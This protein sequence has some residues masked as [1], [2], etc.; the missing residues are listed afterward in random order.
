M[1]IAYST[2]GEA[3]L[4]AESTKRS[5]ALRNRTS[6]PER[7][8]IDTMYDRQVTGNL[9]REL[10]TLTLWAQTY[11]RDVTAHGLLAGFATNGTGRYELCLE[12]AS[13]AKALDP[14]VVYTYNSQIMCNL[15]LERLDQAERA[16]QQ[17]A[18]TFHSPLLGLFGYHLAFL[19]G[20]RAGMDR[21]VATAPAPR[22]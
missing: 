22:P 2:I 21:Q 3:A 15:F 5:Y 20:D 16:W 14:E 13:K 11:P 8:F 12:E 19:K 7:F 1:G 10:Q 4:S 17:A 6:D 9:E 18:T